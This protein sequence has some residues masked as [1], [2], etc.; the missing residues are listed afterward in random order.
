MP[1]MSWVPRSAPGPLSCH[2]LLGLSL[3]TAA[4]RAPGHTGSG[5]QR[6]PGLLCRKTNCSVRGLV[7][8]QQR[9]EG[10]ALL[11]LGSPEVRG[12]FLGPAG[13]KR[14]RRAGLSTL[15]WHLL[16]P[17]SFLFIKDKLWYQ[18]LPK[19]PFSSHPVQ[20]YGGYW[21]EPCVE[22][23]NSSDQRFP[24]PCHPLILP[25]RTHFSLLCSRTRDLRCHP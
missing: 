19:I 1:C 3:K 18:N 2:L 4:P 23:G 14:C 15:T 7:L 8:G 21:A 9:G 12:S 5:L 13:L 24:T 22:L 10:R 6:T 11:P 25:L 17:A 20:G 16:T